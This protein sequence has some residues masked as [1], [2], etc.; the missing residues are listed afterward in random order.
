[1]LAQTRSFFATP[2]GQKIRHSFDV[3]SF[4]Y[5]WLFFVYMT[6]YAVKR[7][8]PYVQTPLDWQLVTLYFLALAVTC[9]A[10]VIGTFQLVRQRK[11]NGWVL[12]ALGVAL[13]AQFIAAG[14]LYNYTIWRSLGLWENIVELWQQEFLPFLS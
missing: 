2:I 9:L 7:S 3:F 5:F 14:V 11:M 13:V 12:V 1:M 6:F 8:L 10:L 4:I